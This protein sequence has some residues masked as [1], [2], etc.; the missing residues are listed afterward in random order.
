[1]S[2]NFSTLILAAGKGTRMKSELPKVLHRACGRSLLEHV[3]LAATDAGA[4]RHIVVVGHG[5]EQVVEELNSFKMPFEAAW[6]KEQ[7]GTGHA[8]LQALGKIQDSELLMIVN[9]DGPLLRSE[10]LTAILDQHRKKSADITL[11]VLSLTNPTGYGRVVLA[12]GK[13]KKIVEEKEASIKQKKIQLVNGGLYVIS[14]KLLRAL[15]MKVKPSALT[16]EIYLTDIIDLAVKAKKKLGVFEFPAEELLGVNDMEQLYEV[17]KVLRKRLYRAWMKNGIKM[18]SP[19]TVL[20]DCSV[21]IHEGVRIGSGVILEGKT[22]VFSK[23]VVEAGCVIRDAVI[24][25]GVLVKAYSYIEEAE[26]CENAQVG[27]FARIRPK[28]V[29]SSDTKIG[30]FVEIKNARIGKG[31]KVSHL[32]YVGDAEIGKDVNIGCGF[33]ACNYDGVNK[34]ITTIED[35]AFVGSAVQAVAPVTVGKGAYVAT[36]TTLTRSVPAGALAIARV[37]Q[38]NKEGYSEKLR[39]RMLAMKKNKGK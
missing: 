29:L 37:K 22:E 19:E 4:Q 36:G 5:G 11:G 31:S 3:M 35:D 24:R 8:A 6:Q 32:S 9:G 14:G 17:E 18:D 1:M 16:H 39:S 13:L 38:E 10:S 7:K 28:T 20:A 33:I 2:S 15:L 23:S 27:P 34:H 12:K 25:E 30:N 21:K 26:I